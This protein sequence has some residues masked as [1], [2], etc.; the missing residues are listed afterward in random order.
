MYKN[1]LFVGVSDL[2][3]S[4]SLYSVIVRQFDIYKHIPYTPSL[5]RN[6]CPTPILPSEPESP[7]P[8][9]L[10]AIIGEICGS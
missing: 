9:A 1:K 4:F 3:N 7:I 5:H 6:E 8:I 2:V 10:G